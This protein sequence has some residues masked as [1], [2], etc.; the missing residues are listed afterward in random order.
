MVM[1][2]VHTADKSYDAEASL[3]EAREGEA[4]T[5]E[6]AV[7]RVTA[8]EWWQRAAQRGLRHA[9]VHAYCE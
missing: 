2:F 1:D 8:R 6:R 3:L 7:A 5:A 4:C 9:W